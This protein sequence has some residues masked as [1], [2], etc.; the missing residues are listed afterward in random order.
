MKK[1]IRLAAVMALG[2]MMLVGLCGCGKKTDPVKEDLYQYLSQMSTVQKLQQDAISKYNSSVATQDSRVLYDDLKN[3]IL[4]GYNDYITQLEAVTTSTDEMG[5][6]KQACVDASKKQL[7]ALEEVKVAIEETDN[8]KLA[9]A[10]AT[11]TEAQTMFDDYYAQ[12]STLAN[13]HGVT[14]SNV[15]DGTSTDGDASTEADASSGEAASTEA[16]EGAVE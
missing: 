9:A 4:P 6:V 12:M 10:D 2:T 11:I 3:T 14:L 13:A 16:T 15:N 1:V 7:E 5:A 8:E